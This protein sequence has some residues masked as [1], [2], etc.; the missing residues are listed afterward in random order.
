MWART[1]ARH[2]CSFQSS[3]APKDRCNLQGQL[4]QAYPESVSILTG[5]EGPVQRQF[6]GSSPRFRPS[7]QSSPAP[8]DR[9]NP[10]GGQ[11]TRSRACFNPHR[12]RRTGATAVGVVSRVALSCFNPHRPR[13]TGATRVHALLASLE[14]KFQSSPAPK[15]R[16]NSPC[17][18]AMLG[19]T[20]FQ[21][22]PAPKDRCNY[23]AAL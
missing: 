23:P 22:S 21:S 16:C 15:D 17:K 4:A 19:L 20:R 12:P 6:A 9:C 3:P 10:A 14:K 5:P 1:Q 7:F 18:R 8:K 2:W 11:A 13:R